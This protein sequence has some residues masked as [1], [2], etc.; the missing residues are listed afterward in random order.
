MVI[1]IILHLAMRRRTRSLI[2]PALQFVQQRRELNQRRLRLRHWILLFLRCAAIVL[3]ALALARPSVPSAAVADWLIVGSLSLITVMAAL[4]TAVALIQR[5]GKALSAS[6]AG[7]TALLAVATGLAAQGTLRESAGLMLGDREAPVSAL[8]V[9]DT[10]PT[11]TYLRNNR[12]RLEAAQ[13]MALWLTEQ[14]P[15]DSEVAVLDARPGPAVFAVDLAAARKAIERLQMTGRPDR[16]SM[17]IE[18]ALQLLP[19]ARHTRQELYVFTDLTQSRWPRTSNDSLADQLAA[20]SQL[21][22]YVIDVGVPQPE[23]FQLGDV[24][25][26]AQSLAQDEPLTITTSVHRLG[27][28]QRAVAELYV[29]EPSTDRPVIVNGQTLLPEARRRGRREMD[30]NEGDRQRIEFQL[31]QLPPGVHHG[32]VSLQ[33]DDALA[34]DNTRYFSV[35]VRQAW[36]VL[37]AAP[38]GVESMFLVEAI[39]PYEYRRSGRARFRCTVIEQNDLANQSLDG[40]AIVCLVNP[41]PMPRAIWERLAQYVERGG[42]LAVFLGHR[43][44]PITS[45]QTD[46]A[47]QVLG[48]RLVR[49]WRAPAG[50]VFL[51]P[52][53]YDHP[54][55][56]PLRSQAT[57]VPWDMAPVFRHWVIEQLQPHA[58]VVIAYSNG[59]PALIENQLGKGIVLTMTTPVSDPAQPAGRKPWNELPTSEEAWPYFVL[60]NEMM[61]YLAGTGEGKL[62]YQTGEMA[63][64]W[65]DPQ[66]DPTRYQLFPPNEPPQE[67][68]AREDRL[69]VGFTD[70]PGIYRLK[71]QRGQP[72]IRGFSVNVPAQLTDLTRVVPAELDGYFGEERYQLAR[73]RDE[74]V[75][76]VEQTRG[77]REFYPFLVAVLALVLVLEHLLANRFYRTD[78]T[79]G[80]NDAWNAMLAKLPGTTHAART[81]REGNRAAASERVGL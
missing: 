52:D 44:Q 42:G 73:N 79:G 58:S 36:P 77:G 40:Y 71:G 6:L 24:Q 68:I 43:A 16:L 33:N 47:Q 27:P 29:E 10:A 11:M 37:V 62:N 23:N 51:A 28:A 38:R 15:S 70:Q 32:Y 8:F 46:S 64:L 41:A 63:V 81:T 53:R 57:S 19:S 17:A 60:V 78:E 3:L 12:T 48:G 20:H 25:L 1:P 69:A 30:L 49:Q 55:L 50:D 59:Q 21:S 74:I 31:K 76:D 26:S 2:F 5:R 80:M 13:Q 66:K 9:I 22:L 67:V 35:Q 39:A 7:V 75:R 54:V 72:V 14:L 18:R 61:N 34:V 4:L 56:A 45:F 65:N